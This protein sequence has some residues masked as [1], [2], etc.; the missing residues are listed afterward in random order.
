MSL[1]YNRYDVGGFDINFLTDCTRFLTPT[2]DTVRGKRPFMQP[3]ISYPITRSSWYVTPKLT[4]NTTV[5]H[6]D[7]PT[8]DMQST[9]I[10]RTL[11][12]FSLDSGTI[13]KYDASLVSKL[14]D[15]SYIQTLELR[16]FYVYTSYRD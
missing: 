15:V 16:V 3:T 10:N 11:P 9:Q 8:N 6:L 14:F 13:F 2:V 12:A 7:H 4:L 5:Y 1:T